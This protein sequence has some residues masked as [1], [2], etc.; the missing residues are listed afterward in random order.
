MLG[1]RLDL[2]NER[3]KCIR[4]L[5][6]R[7][8]RGRLQIVVLNVI[9]DAVAHS[10]DAPQLVSFI[11]SSFQV[12]C[13]GLLLLKR[14]AGGVLGNSQMTIEGLVRDTR[15]GDEKEAV[16][17]KGLLGRGDQLGAHTGVGTVKQLKVDGLKI[18]PC[19]FTSQY[20]PGAEHI[21]SAVVTGGG[22][23]A[24]MAG[25]MADLCDAVVRSTGDWDTAVGL[26]FGIDEFCVLCYWGI[27]TSVRSW[28]RNDRSM[29]R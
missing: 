5:E 10:P 3:A 26:M 12:G 21:P 23:K 13:I 6:A 25:A 29:L 24:G 9:L 8:E 28:R 15:T 14:E 27:S 4:V 7:V 18:G 19:H 17:D 20:C 11:A 16:F 2:G 22:T 1:K